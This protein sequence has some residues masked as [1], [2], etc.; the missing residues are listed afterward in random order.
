MCGN[1]RTGMC[2]TQL[3]TKEDFFLDEDPEGYSLRAKGFRYQDTEKKL[4]KWNEV[5]PEDEFS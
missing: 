5:I 3:G 2:K 4:K 1:N